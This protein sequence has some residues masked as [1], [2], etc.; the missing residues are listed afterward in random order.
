MFNQIIATVAK[1]LLLPLVIELIK[2]IVSPTTKDVGI[3]DVD[4]FKINAVMAG[5]KH[6]KIDIVKPP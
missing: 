5:S 1:E 4:A 3:T 2:Y 6:N